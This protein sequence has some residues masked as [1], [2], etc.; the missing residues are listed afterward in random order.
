MIVSLDN[1]C[2]PEC[3]FLPAR[4]NADKLIGLEIIANFVGMGSGVRTPTEL[5]RRYMT[6][7]EELSLFNEKLALL[8]TCQ[9][10]FI[11]HHLLAWINISPVIVQALLTQTALIESVRRFPFLEF[12][13]NENYPGLNTLNAHHALMILAKRFNLVLANFG[14]GDASTKA[15]FA[16]IFSRITIDKT[17]V[18][19]RVLSPSF[20]PFMRAI[21]AQVLPHC[22]TMM[23]A[24]IDNEETRRRV[25]PFGFSA[26]QGALWPAVT[27]ERVTTLVQG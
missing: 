26:M 6:P 21:V 24:G 22:A 3:L 5:V 12:T 1:A 13:I 18:Q 8:E 23:I 27:A 9:L 2:R 17:F 19:R 11:Q 15:I 14:A 25:K 10:F 16:G 4:N 7:D 20:E